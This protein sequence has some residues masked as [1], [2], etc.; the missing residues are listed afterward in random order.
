MQFRSWLTSLLG[1][2]G[3]LG[4]AL[5][6]V[7]LALLATGCLAGLLLRRDT[8]DVLVRTLLVLG[9][10]LVSEPVLGNLVTRLGKLSRI[11]LERRGVVIAHED[12][13]ARM[14]L[15]P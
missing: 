15:V 1:R 11:A 9:A 14:V 13:L 6:L 2:G 8:N 7:A 12:T 3:R 10:S 5:V 4:L